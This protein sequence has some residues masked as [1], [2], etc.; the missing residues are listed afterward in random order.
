MKG[1]GAAWDADF[2]GWGYG[3]WVALEDRRNGTGGVFGLEV[4]ELEFLGGDVGG[5]KSVM[6]T[7][8]MCGFIFDKHFRLRFCRICA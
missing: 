3:R 7:G 2:V 8:L 4:L 6:Q 1:V 5:E